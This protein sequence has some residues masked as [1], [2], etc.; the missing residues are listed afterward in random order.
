MNSLRRTTGPVTVLVVNSGRSCMY[1]CLVA[2]AALLQ[3][4]H[5]RVHARTS[6]HR[7]GALVG[8]A[9]VRIA[10]SRRRQHAEGHGREEEHEQEGG[11]HGC[12]VRVGSGALTHTCDVQLLDAA[13]A[14]KQGATREVPSLR[15][16]APSWPRGAWCLRHHG[17]TASTP[18][19]S[20][21]SI[22]GTG[23]ARVHD[24]LDEIVVRSADES[25]GGK[26]ITCLYKVAILFLCR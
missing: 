10:R 16:A 8:V 5:L 7:A 2:P 18:D 25:S 6:V 3:P 1:A 17:K 15:R 23:L 12:V 11:A 26:A 20:G 14:A 19:S 21:F 4:P 24:L 22:L 9:R 13:S